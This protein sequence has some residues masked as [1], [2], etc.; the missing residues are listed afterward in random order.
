M[1][2]MGNWM[3]N[4]QIFSAFPSIT[5]RSV[6]VNK[7]LNNVSIT[8][9]DETQTNFQESLGKCQRYETQSLDLYGE[10]KKIIRECLVSA[11]KHIIKVSNSAL[12]SKADVLLSQMGKIQ[13]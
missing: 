6:A 7:Y 9:I 10:K 5:D 2:E 11:L 12:M 1:I 4:T 3:V 13:R 8:P